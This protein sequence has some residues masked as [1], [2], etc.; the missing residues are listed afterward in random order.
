MPTIPPRSSRPPAYD[1]DDQGEA[2]SPLT[3]FGTA[4]GAAFVASVLASGPAA[5]RVSEALDG[6]GGVWPA[7]AAAE[8]P[9]MLIAVYVLRRAREGLRAFRGPDA[10]E[11]ALALAIGGT[12]LLIVLTAMGAVLRATT[13][14]HA[15]AG[16]TF[17][18]MALS[19][20]T[21][22]V[23]VSARTAAIARGWLERGARVRLAL[24]GV[25]LLAFVGGAAWRLARAL[26]ANE[27][28]SPTGSAVVVDLVAFAVAAIL[29]S[30]PEVAG[31]RLLAL[32]GPPAAAVVFALGVSSLIRSPSLDEAIADYAPVFAPAV[33]VVI[34]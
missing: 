24:F 13:H 6:G 5:L 12:L 10:N 2:I 7:L 30:R 8:L 18:A 19:V 29:A 32:F 14:H 26:P 11:R 1:G 16:A 17:A 28:L 33:R 20:A 34:H 22:L 4:V 15:L 21:V 9:A 3:A 27:V 31:R 23:P 25:L